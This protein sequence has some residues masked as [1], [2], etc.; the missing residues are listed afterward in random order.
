MYFL[1]QLNLQNHIIVN[2]YFLKIK[3]NVFP[4]K[5]KT[6]VT[7]KILIIFFKTNV[8]NIYRDHLN[9]DR[10][11]KSDYINEYYAT[12]LLDWSKSFRVP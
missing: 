9:K 7:F 10:Q 3:N 6:K 11:T 12:D 5:E 2:I 1:C 4:A 8:K